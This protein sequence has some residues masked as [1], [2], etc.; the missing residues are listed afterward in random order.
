[1]VRSSSPCADRARRSAPIAF[2]WV[3]LVLFACSLSATAKADDTDGAW[4]SVFDWPLIAVHAALTPDGRVLTYGTK[5][6][7]TQTGYFI[8]DTWDPAAG[9]D[10][11]HM[12][13]ENMTLTDI[14]CSSQI[15]LPQSGDIL[16]AGGDNWTGTRTTN[17]GNN[18]SNIFDYDDNTLA[19]SMNMHRA[20]W[21]SSATALLDGEIYIQGGTGG[22][23][24]PEVRETDGDFRLLTG[25]STSGYAVLFPRNFL[26]PDGRVFGYDTSGKM[27]FVEPEGT[28]SLSPVGQFSSSAAGWQSGAA[29][30]EPGRIVQIGPGGTVVIDIT[31][32]TPQ[33][34]STEPTSSPRRW[35][36]ATV[37]PDGKVLATGG[38]RVD[39]QLTDVNNFAEIWDPQTGSWHIGAE[40]ALARLYHSSAVLLPDASVLVA[41]GGAP[42]PLN[43]TNAEIYYP[44]YLFDASGEFASRPEIVSAPSVANVGD[45]LSVQVN[46]NVSRV[47]LVKTGSVTHSVNMDQRFLELAFTSAAN[48][49]D[50]QLPTRT[51]DT[52]PG[53]YLMFIIDS[54]GVPS[55]ASM[56]RINIDPT[57]DTAVDYTPTIGGG[58]GS[59][60]QLACPADETVVGIHGVYETYVNQVGPQ[61]VKVDQL[62]RWIRDP[63]DGA[64]TGTTTSGTAFAK[65][66][67]RD[68]AVSGFRGRS[69]Q[70][71][72][73]LELECRAL[74]ADGTLTGD[75]HYLGGDGGGGGTAQPAQSCGTGNP[76][77][78][79]YGRSGGWLD[80]FGVECRPATIT[81]ISIN[82]SPVIVNP[83]D[84]SGFVG[85]AVD[86][87]LNATDGDDD[88]LTFDAAG[89][90]PGLTIGS[91][92]GRI[93]GLPDTVGVYDVSVSVTDGSDSDSVD[94]TWEIGAAAPL[95]VEEMPAQDP[96][97]VDT[98][99]AYTAVAAGGTDVVYKWNFGDDTPETDY[100]SS[101]SISHTYSEPGVFY[102]TL[103][104]ND[105][106]GS[107]VVQ[108]FVQAVHRPVT[109]ERPTHSSRIVYEESGAG[110]PRVWIANPDNDTVT[111]LDATTHAKQT[112]IAVGDG[113][114]TLG[115]AADGRVWVV[116]RDSASISV[117]DPAALVVMQTLPLPPASA[118][119]GIA[120]SPA[121]NEAWVALEAVGRLL[122]L[123][124][125]TGDPLAD[126]AVGTHVRHVSVDHDGSIVYVSRFRTP[127][128]PD[129][130]TASPRTEEGGV[131][132]GGEVL[133]VDAASAT[134]QGTITLAHSQVADAENQGRGV[135][136]YLGAVTISPDGLV[137][138]VPSKL[139]NIERGVLRDGLNLN[140]Q[141]T[142]RAVTSRIDPV[143][144]SEDF[145][146]RIDHDNASMVSA[147]AYDPLGIYEF[148]ALETSREV[149][150][151]DAHGG[152]E[153]FRIATGIA[154]QGLLISPDGNKLFVSNFMDRSVTVYDL[155]ALMATGDWTAP[156]LDTVGTVSSE[157][158][159]PQVLRGKQLFYDA[160]DDRLARD[161]Y[162]SCASCHNDGGSDGRVW[163]LTGM[164][165][166]L[167]NTINLRGPAA[168]HGRLHW[169]QNFDEVQDFEGQIRLLAGG[170][171]LMSDADFNAGTRSDPLGDSK[172]GI[173]ADLDA[174]AA[175]IVSLDRFDESPYRDADG[176]LTDDGEAG[177]EI[178][179]RENCADC[180]TGDNFSDSDM[181]ALHD[182]GTIK[183]SSGQRLYSELTGIDTPTLRG[184]WSTAP[185]LHDGSAA[186]LAEAV[187]AHGGVSLGAAEMQQ[188]VAYLVQIDAGES[189]APVP[190]PLAELI[191]DNEDANT[192]SSGRWKSST[193]LSP[194]AGDSVYSDNNGLFSWYPQVSESGIYEVY[195]W[196]TYHVNRASSVPYR[197]EHD[198]GVATVIVD[199]NDDLLG[200]QWVLLGTYS[201]S[202]GVNGTVTVSSENGQASADAVKLVL[203]ESR[204][205]DNTP[206][207][208]PTGLAATAI[209]DTQIDL[210]WDP[211][212]DDS[213]IVSYEI[214]QDGDYAQPVA[215]IANET[216]FSATGL[217][218]NTTYVFEVRA[219]DLS[220]NVSGLSAA[221]TA[222]TEEAATE[223]IVDN[224]DGS[225]WSSGTWASSSGADPW[226]GGSVYSNA[227]GVF[228]W[229]PELGT[230]GI[231]EVYAWWTYH[232][233][234]SSNVPYRI[235]HDAG[236]D[237][238]VVAQNDQALGGQWVLL[239]TYG[240]TAGVNGTVSVSSENGQASAD[241]VRLVLLESGPPDTTPP[242]DPSGL[243]ATAISDTQ[244][245][246]AWTASTDDS[247]TGVIYRIYQD[248]DLGAPIAAV[249]EETSFAV[250]GLTASTGYTFEVRA[251]DISGNSS[252]LSNA[253]TAT[254]AEA[255]TELIVDNEDANTSSSGTWKG[256]SGVDP[257]SGGS[258]YSD[259][260]GLFT[261]LPQLGASGT[262]EVYVW[263]TYHQNRSSSVPYRIEHD[264]GVATVVVDQNDQSLG[265]QWILIGTYTFTA[266][267]N[268]A[269]S[270]SSENGQASADAV[271]LVRID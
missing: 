210:S 173:S 144:N 110:N 12:T 249:T 65:T 177:R 124:G 201:I 96:V 30:F 47:T 91:A 72:D 250:T 45:A 226:A 18:N 225:T 35:V 95:T 69:G 238:V 89:L 149:A 147:T 190:G 229:E 112:E 214:Y 168:R 253:A 245:D 161:N 129:E 54:A 108:T 258:V 165:E 252:G 43:N 255:P 262:Y 62:G 63:A 213:S 178:F 39:N 7:G 93:T 64:L 31:G 235:E 185:Y 37:L 77:F 22:G 3:S 83:G 41:G 81:E 208:D 265:G 14:F 66:C 183:A 186:T 176:T 184:L 141:N 200:G 148:A 270:V 234:R 194:W 254:T 188:L 220:G 153:I 181:D 240:L 132:R 223:V 131:P 24:L 196:W 169:S 264:G 267:A 99:V 70:Y 135:P 128:Q 241:A 219:I 58:G 8:Y 56:L 247:L 6:D 67:P 232:Q 138:T 237:T 159:A 170:T 195:A 152:F 75:P 172:Q 119:Y 163:D 122:K 40:G 137:A 23:D 2:F 227:S 11:G 134:L 17:T 106:S 146:G 86:L 205:P 206:P 257:W 68:Y 192:S 197:I 251:S 143:A 271:K 5:G 130:H 52:P 266:G 26:A 260:D 16:I 53:Y 243:T 127:P 29:M 105:A 107:P 111:V 114:R 203:I 94:F 231:Y 268:G 221:V 133:V 242:T 256:S 261:W 164:G 102:V 180:H 71:V 126:V 182:I 87:Q 166:G 145:T 117:I 25:A 42:G 216:S 13:L 217:T 269:V 156:L 160:A 73:Q 179:R 189:T 204:P 167:R 100:Q 233:N 259:R 98:E 118:P 76:V 113:P 90:P 49:L 136:N 211:S 154:P 85:S 19:R 123:D 10:G 28:G 222:T 97:V 51:S 155:T 158:L 60:F 36:S 88:V 239:G 4:S 140:F 46:G 263:W 218:A 103:T 162:M 44:P 104:V 92:T 115:I 191:V 228:N 174:L 27:Y 21:Y 207:T 9:L 150:V 139:D 32:P 101:P 1:M 121:A 157:K 142:V 187:A 50:I 198:G 15:I 55:V 209:S 171:G 212:T 109:A 74:T 116:N 48:L 79:L 151:I 193:G 230:S 34:T 215:T 236:I 57:P 61:C 248:G 199:Q 33:V 120:F 202:A 125:T 59:P 224:S 175:Y 80:S 244:I 82:S 246:L 38:S 84:Q 78:A 20:R